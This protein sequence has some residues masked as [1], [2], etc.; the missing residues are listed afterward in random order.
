[1][2]IWLSSY[3]KN[4]KQMRIPDNNDRQ[5]CQDVRVFVTKT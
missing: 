5:L 3:F 2:L 4:N 1:M